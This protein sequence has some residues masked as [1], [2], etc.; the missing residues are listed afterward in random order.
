MT[1]ALE[2]RLAKMEESIKSVGRTSIA[3]QIRAARKASPRPRRTRALL[4]QLATVAGLTGRLARGDLRIGRV[5][6]ST[7]PLNDPEAELAMAMG[8]LYAE[9][10]TFVIWAYEWGAE[11]AL[12]LVKLPEPW[13]LTYRSEHGPDAWACEILQ[14][15][16]RQVRERKFD[17]VT[18]VEAIRM[19]V[20]SGHGIG[21]GVLTSWLADW[22]MSTRPNARGV[23]TAST[24]PQLESKTWAQ[25]ATWTKRCVTAHWFNVTTG[26]GSMK[27]TANEAPESWRCDAQTSKQENSESF[28]G[29]HAADS[30]PFYLV[31]ESSGVPDSIANVMQGGL[32]DGE[33]FLVALGNPTKNTGWFHAAFNGMRHRWNTRQIDSRTVQITN[34]SLIQ[35]WVDDFGESS[36]FVKVKVRGLFPHASSLQFIPRDLVDEAAAREVPGTRNEAACVGVDVARFGDD[37]SVI[38]TRIGRDARSF[39]PIRLRGVD[40]MQ[41]ASRVAEHI[42][43]LRSLGLRVHVFVDGGGVGGGVV[44]RLRQLGFDP[45]EVQ[46]GGKADDIRKYANKRAEIWGRAKEWLKVGAIEK[47][48]ALA[49]D[50]TN[51]DYSFNVRDQIQLERKESMKARGLSSPDDADALALTFAH[52]VSIAIPEAA[53]HPNP[54]EMREY[55]PLAAMATVSH[56]NRD[57][58]PMAFRR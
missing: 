46:F 25:I 33:P 41:L 55:D 17:G 34:K 57:Y 16:G 43:Y 23:V 29:L 22:I 7:A 10:L 3:Q 28:A 26:R 8:E 11:P 36:D 4:E 52:P 14:D 44:D 2:R 50:L 47:D 19:A 38:R 53:A 1:R 58:D 6:D 15:I 49:T 27:M 20:S 56:G 13:S 18:P 39:A 40:T 45:V 31:D 42:N 37:A 51:V 35:Q 54:A 5:G 30:S 32:T 24:S 12:R 48:E 21:K 9:P